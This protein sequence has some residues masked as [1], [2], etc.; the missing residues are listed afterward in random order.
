VTIAGTDVRV[1]TYGRRRFWSLVLP[2]VGCWLWQGPS[3]PAGYGQLTGRIEGRVTCV[4]SHRIAYEMFVG[5][6][7]SGMEL[8]HLCRNRECVNPDHL[9]VVTPRINKLRAA[10]AQRGTWRWMPGDSAPDELHAVAS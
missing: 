1:A 7:P 8:D 9:Q 4:Q 6:V 10:M 2:R 5:S 3:N